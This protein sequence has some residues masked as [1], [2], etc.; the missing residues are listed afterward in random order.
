MASSALAAKAQVELAGGIPLV[1]DRDLTAA[2]DPRRPFSGGDP[3][4]SGCR[5]NSPLGES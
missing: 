1:S 4:P 5:A 3:R 2:L